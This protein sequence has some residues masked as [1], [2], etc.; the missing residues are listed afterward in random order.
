[1]TKVKT[2]KIIIST[3]MY[4]A[5]RNSTLHHGYKNFRVLYHIILKIISLTRYC[6][7]QF[8]FRIIKLLTCLYYLTAF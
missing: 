3:T 7:R 4:I 1:M 8:Y 6:N 2:G 5:P